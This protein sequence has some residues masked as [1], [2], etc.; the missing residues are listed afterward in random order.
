MLLFRL[1]LLT[2]IAVIGA[3]T[4]ITISN[5][6]I[7]LLPI[8]FGDMA[9]MGWPGQ[10]NLDFLFFLLLAMIWIAWRHQFSAAG[11]ALAA[12]VPAGGMPYVATYLLVHSYRTNGDVAALLLGPG[13]A[14]RR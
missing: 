4:A 11:L 12:L 6:G 13:R 7:N 3:Y 14:A 1:F 10:F 9:K 2:A 5:H 8:F